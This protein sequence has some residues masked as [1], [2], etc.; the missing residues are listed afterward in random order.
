MFIHL[1]EK[2]LESRPFLLQHFLITILLPVQF[3]LIGLII[4]WIRLQVVV[5]QLLLEECHR[6]LQVHGIQFCEIMETIDELL[7]RFVNLLFGQ[8]LARI[9]GHVNLIALRLD[10]LHF[11]EELGLS[12]LLPLL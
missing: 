11:V 2:P 6:I 8:C 4:H 7:N 9:I 5:F 12:L 10:V 1:F 3:R